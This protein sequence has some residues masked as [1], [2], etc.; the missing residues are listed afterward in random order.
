[1]NS[2]YGFT[3]IELLVAMSIV[4][5]IGVIALGG[6]NI[7]LQQQTMAEERA[8]RWREIQFAMRMIAQDLSQI[9]PRT[10]RDEMGQGRRPSVQVNPNQLYALEFS[11]GGW[12]N[13]VNLPRGNV[14]R[15]A[16]DWEATD[17]TLVRYH[18]PVMD[19][20]LQTL[21]IRTDLLSGVEELEISL[22]DQANQWHL[23]EWPPF[24]NGAANN[25]LMTTP[26]AIRF[27]FR[28]NDYGS[29]WRTIETGG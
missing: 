29:I 17:N 16:Y 27:Q 14:L 5:I 28:L 18:W 11:R 25:N 8:E 21:P 13:P 9:H 19:R 10:T 24:N 2:S 3:R 7:V 22:L 6:L 26:R 1:M 20:T 15:V 12:A 4:A 23:G